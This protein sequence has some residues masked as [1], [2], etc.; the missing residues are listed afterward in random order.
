[1]VQWCRRQSLKKPFVNPEQPKQEVAEKPTVEPEQ[2]K[3][4]DRATTL[5]NGEEVDKRNILFE[6]DDVLFEQITNLGEH[7]IYSVYNKQTGRID[8]SVAEKRQGTR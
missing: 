1:M 5:P 2:S 4:R 8:Y 6:D 3:E 7:D